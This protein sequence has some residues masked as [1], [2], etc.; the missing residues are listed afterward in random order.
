M[1]YVFRGRIRIA[2]HSEDCIEWYFD[3]RE[4]AWEWLKAEIRRRREKG[5]YIGSPRVD[6]VLAPGDSSAFDFN[7]PEIPRV[8]NWR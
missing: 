6:S 2:K 8:S 5:L 3:T 4:D 1:H 7:Y